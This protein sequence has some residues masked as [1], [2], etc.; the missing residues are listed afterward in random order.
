MIRGVEAIGL[1][2][3]YGMASVREL[4]HELRKCDKMEAWLAVGKVSRS[5]SRLQPL[6]PAKATPNPD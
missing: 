6:G 5:R 3:P 1:R 4:E 2:V